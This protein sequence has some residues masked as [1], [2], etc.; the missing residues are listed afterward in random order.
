MLIFKCEDFVDA[1][2]A[3]Q[4]LGWRVVLILFNFIYPITT[5]SKLLMRHCPPPP[6]SQRM[7]TFHKIRNNIINKILDSAD[8][9]TGNK[10]EQRGRCQNSTPGKL[11]RPILS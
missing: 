11:W 9:F 8:K 7:G 6:N 3:C 5:E 1:A 2:F 4:R 10:G